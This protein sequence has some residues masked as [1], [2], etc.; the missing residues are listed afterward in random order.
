[1]AEEAALER[2][3]RRLLA[4]MARNGRADGEDQAE[5]MFQLLRG[6]RR[7]P[8]GNFVA[9]MALAGRLGRH[10]RRR[11]RSKPNSTK[12]RRWSRGLH[13]GLW[14]TSESSETTV[15]AFRPADPAQAV[16]S[17]IG[18]VAVR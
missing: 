15:P 16:T 11:V 1:M 7:L 13:P 2:R 8:N 14:G 17:L 12:G 3:S 5:L 4:V 10:A 9:T 6:R 18:I